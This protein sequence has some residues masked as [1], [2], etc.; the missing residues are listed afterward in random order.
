[1]EQ[2]QNVVNAAKFPPLG[3]RSYGG[4]RPIDLQGRGYADTANQEILLVVQIESPEAIENADAIA[5]LPGVDA[6]MLGPDD[7][8]LRRGFSMTTPRSAETLGN[9]MK[10]VADACKKHGKFATTVGVGKEMLELSAGMGFNLIVGGGDVAF[11]ANT[12][13]SASEE[14][15][16]NLKAMN[17]DAE[18]AD[19]NR[20][21]AERK[22]GG[23]Y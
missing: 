6:L 13:K 15:R 9:D 16:A 12:S 7:V 22:A 14:A 4:R 17:F 2:A 11:L 21:Q 18:N 10:A 1:V 23:V 19:L 5:A 20:P 3:K 8:M